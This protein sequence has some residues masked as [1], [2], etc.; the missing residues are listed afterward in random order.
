MIS[1]VILFQVNLVQAESVIYDKNMEE[2]I[3]KEF[4]YIKTGRTSSDDLLERR[5]IDSLSLYF[6]LILLAECILLVIASENY[7]RI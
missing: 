1:F 6:L 3:R 7:Q 4:K 5:I 2:E